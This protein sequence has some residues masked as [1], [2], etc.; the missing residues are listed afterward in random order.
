MIIITALMLAACSGYDDSEE[1]DM[2]GMIEFDRYEFGLTAIPWAVNYNSAAFVLHNPTKY[3]F[4]W[5][6]SFQ[7][8]ILVNGEWTE[9]PYVNG[10]LVHSIGYSLMPESTMLISKQWMTVIEPGIYRITK[11]FMVWMPDVARHR[12]EEI[13]YAEFEVVEG[14]NYDF[15][16]LNRHPNRVLTTQL[17]PLLNSGIASINLTSNVSCGDFSL[18]TYPKN[19]FMATLLEADDV[20]NFT[21]IFNNF[22]AGARTIRHINVALYINDRKIAYA[23]DIADGDELIFNIL[24]SDVGG[25][26]TV[27][28]NSPEHNNIWKAVDLNIERLFGSDNYS[29][30]ALKLV[31]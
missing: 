29:H 14:Q 17:F 22:S 21:A 7:L 16:L 28:V 3:E 13:L 9:V 11:D 23:I 18:I 4:L 27:L 19:S 1:N 31:Q 12:E 5:G 6:E 25:V 2:R 20:G 30:S 8:E 15:W 26:F 24:P 10:G